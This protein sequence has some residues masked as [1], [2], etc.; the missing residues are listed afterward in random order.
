[1]NRV[2]KITVAK[3]HHVPNPIRRVGSVNTDTQIVEHFKRE[4]GEIDGRVDPKFRAWTES[5]GE[6]FDIEHHLTFTEIENLFEGFN[7]INYECDEIG[8]S[9]DNFDFMDT[10]D[11]PIPQRSAFDELMQNRAKV[12]I[13]V[14]PKVKSVVDRKDELFN[15]VVEI[16]ILRRVD[17]LVNSKAKKTEVETKEGTYCVNVITNALWY[18][19]NDHETINNSHKHSPSTIVKIPEVFQ[20]LDGFNEIKRKKQKSLPLERADLLSHAEALYSLLLRPGASTKQ[21]ELFS[22]EVKQ[23]ADCLSTYAEYLRIKAE[24]VTKTQSQMRPARTVSE[25]ISVRHVVST[26]CMDTVYRSIDDAVQEAGLNKAVLF[27]EETHVVTPFEN[28][29]QRH[30]FFEHLKLSVPVDLYRFCPGGSCHTIS[31][32][33]QV[34]EKR[35]ASEVLTDGATLTAKLKPVLREHHTRAQKR[36]FKKKVTNVAG[37]QKSL[38]DVIYKELSL[39]ASVTS[40]PDTAARIH[41]MFLGEEGLV[42][43]LRSLNPGRPGGT[44][45]VF[46]QHMEVYLESVTAPDD[47]RH[48]RSAQMSQWLSL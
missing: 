36:D 24:E 44:F 2:L 11:P 19:T 18:I 48:G 3:C 47:R 13:R 12:H 30:R 14:Y 29:M 34:K 15:M 1:M 23:M 7:S 46:F 26:Q 28:N 5:A 43:D 4:H 17:F 38:L 41:A 6:K 25:D 31:C 42:A 20:N 37:I 10:D 40:H 39:D 32:I 27:D 21:W 22:T 8:E 16:F 35:T 9:D 33:V 45:E